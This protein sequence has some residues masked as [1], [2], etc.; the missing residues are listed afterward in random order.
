MFV[1][2]GSGYVDPGQLSGQLPGLVDQH[3]QALWAEVDRPAAKLQGKQGDLF[4]RSFAVQAGNH[5][6]SNPQS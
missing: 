1:F 5:G 2:N 6:F 3:R 4:V